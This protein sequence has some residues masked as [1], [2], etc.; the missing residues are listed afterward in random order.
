MLGDNNTTLKIKSVVSQLKYGV[1]GN[2][3]LTG[4]G[5]GQTT[6]RAHRAEAVGVARRVAAALSLCLSFAMVEN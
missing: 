6:T 1:I 5:G 3:L 4:G 2:S